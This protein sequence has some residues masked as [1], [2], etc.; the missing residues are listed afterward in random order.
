MRDSA[1]PACFPS[2]SW[3]KGFHSCRQHLC[4]P[5]PFVAFSSSDQPC[6]F[7]NPCKLVAAVEIPQGGIS[8][9]QDWVTGHTSQEAETVWFYIG[10]THSITITWGEGP[11]EGGTTLCR[12]RSKLAGPA[13]CLT[14]F[15]SQHHCSEG[16][17][18]P[19]YCRVTGAGPAEC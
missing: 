9:N 4:K 1:C 14:T 11:C 16:E 6:C 7:L 19:P 18:K 17:E 5:Q 3:Q 12:S 13:W 15:L 10:D 2:L 8:P